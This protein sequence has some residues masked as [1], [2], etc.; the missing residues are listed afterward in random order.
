MTPFKTFILEKKAYTLD[1]RDNEQVEKIFKRYEEYFSPEALDGKDPKRLYKKDITKD[2]FFLGSIKTFDHALKEENNIGV[3]V[4]FDDLYADAAY[5]E[6]S[7][8]IYLYYKQYD[9]LPTLM[10]RNKIVHELLHA[11]QHYK[12]LTPEYRRALNKRIKSSGQVTIRSER[13]YFF[14]PN[15][16][17]VQIASIVH[18][19]DR[20]YRLLLQKIKLGSNV[21]FWENQRRGFLRLLEQFI[22]SPKL[23]E[24]KN[25]PNYLQNE[26]RFLKA[27][28]RNKDNPTY[29]RYY[30]DFKRKMAWYLQN[31][32]GLKV[33][34]GEDKDNLSE[35]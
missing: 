10:K 19:M 34:G 1:S 31:L 24:D 25:I 21:R 12:K 30:L 14:A 28:F 9:L 29:S 16:Y 15:E 23:V 33:H 20:Q 32:K 5:E 8:N 18:E 2:G 7:N 17:P 3:Y 27:L 13:G 4:T 11:K 6:E 35:S 22:R 26:K